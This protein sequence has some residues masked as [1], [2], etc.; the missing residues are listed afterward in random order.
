MFRSPRIQFDTDIY[1]LAHLARI[2]RSHDNYR[3]MP[4]L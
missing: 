2:E 3:H 4:C 1:R